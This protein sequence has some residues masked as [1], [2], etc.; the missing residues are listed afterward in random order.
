MNAVLISGS[1]T[2]S[3]ESI[4]FETTTPKIKLRPNVDY[5]LYVNAVLKTAGTDVLQ[6]DG[7]ILNNQPKAKVR[8][9]VSGSNLG[10]ELK[11][12]K[13]ASSG[14]VGNILG[15]PIKVITGE[16]EPQGE[17]IELKT[18]GSEIGKTIDFGRVK[19]P[20]KPQ[21]TGNGLTTN[22]DTKLQI[23]VE[24]GELFIQSVGIEPSSDTNF[25]PDEFTFQVPM[26]KLRKRPDFF[27]FLVEFYDRDGN[28]A[29][30]TTIKE[31][32]EFDGENDVI[33]GTDNL[34]TGSLSIGNAL[35]VG[36]EAAGV[37]SAYIRSVDY[38]GFDSSSVSGRGGFL[39][40][41]GSVSRSLKT[42]ESYDGVGIELHDGNSGSFKFRTQNADGVGEFDVRTNKFFFGKEGVQFVSGSDNQIEISSSNFH[43]KGDGSLIIGAGATINSSL[44]ANSIL[45]PAGSTTTNALAS[46]TD[47]GAARFTSASIGGFEVTETH[48]SSSG[49]VLKSNGQITGSN[50]KLDG[51]TISENV[52]ISGSF[53]ANSVL[54]PSSGTPLATITS[55]GAASFTSASIGGFNISTT[56]ISSSN[57]KLILKASGQITA[58]S[59]Q[60]TGEL[61]ANAGT[62]FQDITNIHDTTGSLE[63]DISSSISRSIEIELE[64]SSS[65][66]SASL[67]RVS[68]TSSFT[69]AEL[70]AKD[71]GAKAVLSAS[72]FSQ[73]AE[74]S[75]SL[76]G[77]GALTSASVQVTES[78]QF[79]REQTKSLEDFSAGAVVSGAAVAK[80][81][82]QGAEASG[83]L[84]GQGAETSASLLAAG[85][86]ISSSVVLANVTKSFGDSTGS[87][88]TRFNLVGTRTASLILRNDAL[89]KTTGSLNAETASIRTVFDDVATN[90]AS[91]LLATQSLKNAT[92]SL[93]DRLD[94]VSSS[95]HAS[96]ASLNTTLTASFTL[97]T[98]SFTDIRGFTTRSFSLLDEVSSS[99][100]AGTASLTTDRV[101]MGDAIA[102]RSASMDATISASFTLVT[103]SIN[104]AESNAK[105]QAGIFSTQSRLD[106]VATASDFGSGAIESASLLGQGAEA[107]ASLLAFGAFKSASVGVNASHSLVIATNSQSRFEVN[108]LQSETTTSLNRFT[109]IAGRSASMDATISASFTLVTASFTDVRGFTTRSFSL[110]DEVSSS[111]GTGTA[112]LTTDRVAMGDAIAIR[113]ASMDATISASFTLVTASFTDVRGFTT[114][115]FSLLDE[116]S[117]SYG[118]GTASLTTDR[119]AMGNAIASRSE[120]LAATLTSSFS[121]LATNSESLNTLLTASF[122][123]IGAITSSF[124]GAIGARSASMDTTLTASFG[125]IGSIT[126]S[127]LGAIGARSASMDATLTA[128]FGTIASISASILTQV[129][130]SDLEITSSRAIFSGSLALDEVTFVSG[131]IAG[132]RS[133]TA[134]GSTVRPMSDIFSLKSGDGIVPAGQEKL[135]LR[136][137]LSIGG[138]SGG[139]ANNLSTFSDF[140]N[141]CV[142]PGTKIL[143]K[144]DGRIGK[145]NIE[146]TRK[147]DL[148]YVFDFEKEEFGFSPIKK[149]T[150]RITKEGWSHIIT[151]GGYE[152]KC[153]NSHLLYHPDYPGHAIKTNELGIGGQLYVFKNN[154]IIGDKI[155]SIEV[156]DEP[157][158]VWN[159]EL[160]FTHNYISNGILSHNAVTKAFTAGHR[161][162]SDI[163][164]NLEKGDLVKLSENNEI[165]KTTEQKDTSVL[166]IVWFEFSRNSYGVDG[167]A[168][169]HSDKDIFKRDSFGKVYT[170]EEMKTKKLWKI[171]AIGDTRFIDKMK[172]PQELDGLKVCNQNGE[173]KKGD[174]LCSS[175]T[176]GYAMK[177]PTEFVITSVDGI[178][179]TGYDE[180][181]NM[182]S[183]TIGKSM[184]DVEFDKNGIADRVYGYLYCV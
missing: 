61:N 92:A 102:I 65:V 115:S 125:T 184:E 32:V 29:G 164:E 175:D 66:T 112:S 97:V 104:T 133:A 39:M 111:Y 119:I 54:L 91:I 18:K 146:D 62:V 155:K 152:L 177:Q 49:L 85:A 60:L 148:I 13:P 149:I 38:A 157:V 143:I 118:A 36:I 46:I 156:Y 25:N 55:T 165:V 128:S 53:A 160:E 1:N 99:Y 71:Y 59:V 90:T 167:D 31:A 44:S 172:K 144:R 181:Q 151:E 50:F 182:S 136:A 5:T 23:E 109:A 80:E 117:S 30:Y 135:S 169:E 131:G 94:V 3:D 24:A 121:S 58:S 168:A 57:G 96:T 95:F 15:D 19:I 69:E 159:Y 68:L 70:I 14:S 84:F 34:L 67:I 77:L 98:A 134:T 83:A 52:T 163:N 153:S 179:P 22:D 176:S 126:S 73:G 180:R 79:T 137:D 20:F 42:S 100:G 142:L 41:S 139:E 132:A 78:I 150:N 56:A 8:F 114:R 127:F 51:G 89:E 105:T 21:F 110:L 170:D 93:F 120:S 72:A 107:S 178:K 37:N 88:N 4:L 161:Y 2:L 10:Q 6:D 47:A 9:Y 28:K 166:G 183:F 48:I 147:D 75:A 162:F 63:T 11:G 86:F 138:I 64:T 129:S 45:V 33:Q 81:F 35:G 122:G 171:A 40:W 17:V 12:V 26:P 7:S 130:S 145:T 82:G 43:L 158:E 87:F 101:A 113:S 174:L 103:A 108:T 16:D 141:T 124:L 173:V 123:T 74:A 106:A 27:D 140:I 76:F 116:V 154:K